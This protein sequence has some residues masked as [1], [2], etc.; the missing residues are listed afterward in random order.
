[1]NTNALDIINLLCDKLG[2]AVDWTTAQI[3][4]LMPKIEEGITQFANMKY[5]SWLATCIMM[6]LLLGVMIW[7][8]IRCYNNDDGGGC[9]FFVFLALIAAGVL[10]GG[11]ILTIQWG[12]AP[13]IK[14]CEQI[15]RYLSAH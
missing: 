7:F 1:M 13:M 14:T 9:G 12:C 15:L 4:E 6:A 8:A 11:V 2:I 3:N 10:I 5:Y